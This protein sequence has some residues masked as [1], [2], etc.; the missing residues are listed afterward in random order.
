MEHAI[1]RTAHGS[2]TTIQEGAAA[3]RALAAATR[4]GRCSTPK[5]TGMRGW[6]TSITRTGRARH[7][8]VLCAACQATGSRAPR[9]T[10]MEARRRRLAQAETDKKRSGDK[11]CS[12]KRRL[13]SSRSPFSV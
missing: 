1:Q 9:A 7:M 10:T 12:R 8:T 5:P 13:E 3:M 2:M 11:R 4:C 6:R